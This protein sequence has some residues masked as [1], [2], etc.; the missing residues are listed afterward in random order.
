MLVD[1]VVGV[2]VEVLLDQL[3]L[4]LVSTDGSQY[5]KGLAPPV[6]VLYAITSPSACTLL[7]VF[8]NP[9]AVM[10]PTPV[11][12]PLILALPLNDCPQMVLAVCNFVA[13]AA[14]PLTFPVIEALIVAGNFKF[15]LPLPLTLTTDPTPVPSDDTIPIFLAVPQ[16]AVV[17]LAEPLKLVPLIVLMVCNVVAVVALPFNRAVIVPLVLN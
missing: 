6:L 16:L 8:I 17:I 1:L 14:L 13:V 11:I 4:P 3:K 10:L 15:T 9:L 12:L 2:V 7:V 5:L